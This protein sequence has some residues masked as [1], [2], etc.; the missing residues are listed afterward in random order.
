MFIKKSHYSVAHFTDFVTFI[1]AGLLMSLM[2]LSFNVA[3]LSSC[4]ERHA[5]THMERRATCVSCV[6]F[7]PINGFEKRDP[8]WR[9]CCSSSGSAIMLCLV[10][11]GLL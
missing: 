7:F 11:F 6:I 2:K 5:T 4:P 3:I 8:T 10:L 1:A 9:R